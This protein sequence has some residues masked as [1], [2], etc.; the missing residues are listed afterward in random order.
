MKSGYFLAAGA[1]MLVVLVASL[2]CAQDKVGFFRVVSPTMTVITAF[3]ADGTLVWSNATADVTCRVQH[4]TTLMGVSNW[5][6]YAGQA[7]TNLLMAARLF[8]FT[9]PSGMVFIPGGIN[10]GTDPDFGAY[11]LKVSS[12]YMDR[13]EVTKA[14]WDEIY[15]WAIAQGY[16]F[17][18][19]GSGKAANHPVHSVSWYDCVKWCNARSEREGRPAVYYTDVGLTQVYRAGQ[20]LNP[21]VKGTAIGYRLP[22]DVE[23]HYAAR[24]GLVGKRFSWGDRIDH[25]RANYYGYPPGYPYDTGYTGFDTRYTDGVTPYTSPVGSFAANGYGAY[26]MAGDLR[27]WCWNWYPGYEGAARVIRGGSWADVACDCQVGFRS[28]RGPDYGS[29]FLGFRAVLPAGQ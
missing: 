24:G 4:A 27:E 13:I 9:A 7:V 16:A 23:W 2:A 1:A 6:D 5:T 21:H 11:S 25:S 8:D 15:A 26:D 28:Y 18:N 29:H 19:A 22:T 10:V 14:M 17:D 3:S 12:F 20:V